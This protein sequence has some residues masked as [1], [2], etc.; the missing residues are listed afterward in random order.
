MSTRS[1]LKQPRA[2][3]ARKQKPAKANSVTRVPVAKA[4]TIRSTGRRPAISQNGQ[5]TIVKHSEFFADVTGSTAFSV[6]AFPL[7]PGNDDVF[8][9]LSD[10]AMRF[11]YY[12]FRSLKFRYEPA[13]STLTTGS[14]YQCVDYDASDLPPGDKINLMQNENAVRSSPYTKCVMD[15]VKGAS[16]AQIKRFTL[17]RAPP[18]SADVKMYN[19]GNAIFATQG[20]L[21]SSA[22]GELYVDYEVELSVPQGQSDFTESAIVDVP[23]AMTPTNLFPAAVVQQ[24]AKR[25]IIDIPGVTSPL[26]TGTTPNYFKIL[27][28][29]VYDVSMQMASSIAPA[30]ATNN[31]TFTTVAGSGVTIAND[32]PTS[33]VASTSTGA[34]TVGVARLIYDAATALPT[35]SF[36]GAV[37]VACTSA[38][39]GGV[40]LANVNRL[41]I[42]PASNPEQIALLPHNV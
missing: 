36:A 14:V 11:E 2:K 26:I 25:P 38:L 23:A 5:S 33:A 40:T 15:M 16:S 13:C 10:I 35:S 8:P 41:R 20:M 4:S 19:L 9:F 3:R 30:A 12:K 21:D 34:T 32:P 6:R 18:P 1:A 28:S 22:V 37:V 42:G 17:D 27:K 29:G 24:D 7:N 31:L 39:A